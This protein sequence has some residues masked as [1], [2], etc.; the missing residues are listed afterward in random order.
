MT[1][2]QII[3]IPDH[4]LSVDAAIMAALE[5]IPENCK[6]F[7]LVCLN[8]YDLI[9]MDFENLI[10]YTFQ[11][12]KRPVPSILNANILTDETDEYLLKNWLCQP[13][14]RKSDCVIMSDISRI[15]TGYNGIETDIVLHVVTSCRNCEVSSLCPV[16]I[17]RAK[18][19]LVVAKYHVPS[20]FLCDYSRVPNRR[21][22]RIKV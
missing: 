7:A 19:L 13:H 5:K 1:E 17:T 20:C 3:K 4:F 11:E 10:K 16:A 18:A 21:R 2:G 22:F 14:E 6:Q 9:T 8:T 15:S 12:M